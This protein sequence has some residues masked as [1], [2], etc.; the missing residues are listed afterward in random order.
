VPIGFKALEQNL[1]AV[2]S[3]CVLNDLVGRPLESF[4]AVD[5]IGGQVEFVPRLGIQY[6][7]SFSSLGKQV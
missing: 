3:D 4:E 2:L 1:P 7:L 5:L 6:S